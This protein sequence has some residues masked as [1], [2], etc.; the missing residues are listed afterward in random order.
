MSDKLSNNALF[1]S[2][3]NTIPDASMANQ[4][5][6]LVQVPGTNRVDAR[7][8]NSSGTVVTNTLSYQSGPTFTNGSVIFANSSNQLT[9]DNANF[10]FNDGSDIL[11]VGSTTNAVESG[12]TGIDLKGTARSVRTAAWT[13]AE[14]QEGNSAPGTVK[15]NNFRFALDFDNNKDIM[16]SYKMPDIYENGTNLTLRVFWSPKDAGAGTVNWQIGYRFVGSGDNFTADRDW[17]T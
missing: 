6:N 15:L 10:F 14:L 1:S 2:G 17:E 5:I 13:A 9:Q 7:I 16:F 11:R 8:K 12:P 4:D 3:K